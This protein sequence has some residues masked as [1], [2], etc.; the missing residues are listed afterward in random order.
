M[1]KDKE[2]LEPT[3]NSSWDFKKIQNS[4]QTHLFK[5]EICFIREG[6]GQVPKKNPF[7]YYP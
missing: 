7:H 6:V 3:P 2:I 5:F 1:G 4:S